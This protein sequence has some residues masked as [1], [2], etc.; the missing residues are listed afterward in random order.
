MQYYV[1][2]FPVRKKEREIGEIPRLSESGQQK[3]QTSSLMYLVM[4]TRL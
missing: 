3:L 2:L 1:R 4:A